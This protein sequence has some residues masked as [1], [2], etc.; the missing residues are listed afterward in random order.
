MPPSNYLAA[1]ITQS[2]ELIRTRLARLEQQAS[3]GE[4]PQANSTMRAIDDELRHAMRVGA[5][6]SIESDPVLRKQR[7]KIGE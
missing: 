1:D 5:T 7:G 3:A 2:V 4:W 6:L